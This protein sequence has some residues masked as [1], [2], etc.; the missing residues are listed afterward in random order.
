M[1][2]S[3]PEAGGSFGGGYLSEHVGRADEDAGADDAAHHE[4]CAVQQRQPALELRSAAFVLIG[5][6]VRSARFMLITIWSTAVCCAS[7]G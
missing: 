4:T 3:S 1:D 7:I 2:V 5:V 6:L